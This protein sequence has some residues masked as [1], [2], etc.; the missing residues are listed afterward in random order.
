MPNRGASGLP[1]AIILDKHHLLVPHSVDAAIIQ[2]CVRSTV[3]PPLAVG[4]ISIER[5]GRLSHT[6]QEA[7]HIGGCDTK[8]KVL[9]HLDRH[10][11]VREIIT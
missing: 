6:A 1:V 10:L 5:I 4:D 8:S 11:I 2:V 7:A 9:R 3:N